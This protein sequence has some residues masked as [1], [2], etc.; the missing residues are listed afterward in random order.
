MNVVF[1]R[2]TIA[3]SLRNALAI[4]NLPYTNYNYK[5]VRVAFDVILAY[6]TDSRGDHAMLVVMVVVIVVEMVAV[7]MLALVIFCRW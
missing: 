1:R 7:L 4:D 6:L 5:Y 3:E 2:R